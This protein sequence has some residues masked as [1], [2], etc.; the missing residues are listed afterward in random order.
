MIDAIQQAIVVVDHDDRVTDW[1]RFAE[2]LYGW[3]RDEALGRKL[4]ELVRSD[5]ID[6]NPDSTP[7]ASERAVTSQVLIHR[8]DG[9]TF[10]ASVTSLA[11]S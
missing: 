7:I 4:R 6:G 5:L 3:S 2:S 10:V 11:N 9:S 1:N 8:R